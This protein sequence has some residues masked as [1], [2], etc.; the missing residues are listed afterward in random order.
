[1]ARPPASAII[2][3]LLLAAALLCSQGANAQQ[4]PPSCSAAPATVAALNTAVRASVTGRVAF[5]G[6]ISGTFEHSISGCNP[7]SSLLCS[8]STTAEGRWGDFQVGRGCNQLAVAAVEAMQQ[9]QT[10]K[11]WAQQTSEWQ[12]DKSEWQPTSLQACSHP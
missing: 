7:A 11:G 8:A 9:L 1:M 10:H 4:V 3:V 2:A 5:G 12:P 6:S